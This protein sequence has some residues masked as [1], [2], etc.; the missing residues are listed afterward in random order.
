MKRAEPAELVSLDLEG[1]IWAKVFHVSPLVLVG[2]LEDDGTPDIAPKHMAMPLGWQNRYCFVCSPRHATF[3]NA[4]ARGAFTVSFPRPDQIVE[5]SM[6]AGGRAEDSTKP[7]L[8]VLRTF[9]ASEVEGPLVEGCYLHLEC[10]LDRVIEGLGENALVMGEIVAAS[11]AE[12]ALRLSDGDD[13]DLIA[14]SPLFAYL[15]PGR[16]AEVRESLSFPFPVDFRF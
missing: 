9:P 2:P 4:V 14:E 16:F 8:A 6:A 13:A 5:A 1:P 15:S 3:R 12:D 10:R 7:S 11:V